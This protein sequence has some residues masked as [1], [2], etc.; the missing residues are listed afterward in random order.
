[1]RPSNSQ[2]NKVGD[3]IRSDNNSHSY[4]RAIDSLNYWRLLHAHPLNIFTRTLRNKSKSYSGSFVAQ[5][6]KRLPTII[7][8]LSR[9]PE[10]EL[11]RMHDIGGAR[12]V[13]QSIDQLDHIT[14][15]YLSSTNRSRILVKKYDYVENPKNDGYRSIHLVYKYM[16]KNNSPLYK[17]LRIEL[18]FRTEIQHEWATA[19]EIISTYRG[20][21]FKYGKGNDDWKEFLSLCSAAFCHLENQP[22]NSKYRSLNLLDIIHR[23]KELDKKH[24]INELLSGFTHATRMTQKSSK[25]TYYTLITL[26]IK[27]HIIYVSEYKKSELNKAYDA[28]QKIESENLNDSMYESVLVASG[29][30][31]ELRKAYPNYFL[32]LNNFAENIKILYSESLKYDKISSKDK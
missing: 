23:M 5:R 10:M 2:I 6:L 15:K 22:V 21:R 19:L 32:D 16:P 1:M 25:N 18:Q 13:L 11:S 12:I 29:K 14:N 8:K 4:S 30:L 24:Q 3:I 9:E 7:D 17:N 20:E 28:L 31:K 27:K 26:D